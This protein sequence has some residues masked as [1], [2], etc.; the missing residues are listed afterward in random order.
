MQPEI[1]VA[2]FEHQ[3]QL[4][5]EVQDFLKCLNKD[6]VRGVT[7]MTA[8]DVIVVLNSG[9]EYHFMLRDIYDSWCLGKTYKRYGD[10]ET[11]YHSGYRASDFSG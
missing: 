4:R 9:T 8:P 7:R 6:D 1:F 10:T 11:I 5:N 3:T 2:V